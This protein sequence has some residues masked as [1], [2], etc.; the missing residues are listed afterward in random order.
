MNLLILGEP[1]NEDTNYR[2]V[3]RYPPFHIDALDDNHP[4]NRTFLLYL[5]LTN[6]DY[7]IHDL[8][9][10]REIVES[11]KT[12]TPPEIYEIIEVTDNKEPPEN[13]E[14]L[15]LGYDPAGK[16]GLSLISVLAPRPQIRHYVEYDKYSED[17]YWEEE[18]GI[19]H[20]IMLFNRLIREHFRPKLN[21]N[22]LFDDYDTAS[23][24]CECVMSILAV[25]PQCY[26]PGRY[27]VV[28]VYLVA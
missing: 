13:S 9:K 27:E 3:D 26:E 5:D 10:A 24:C 17:K 8:A 23:F 19:P 28:G 21:K 25:E 15:F 2:G 1:A 11:Y 20:H 18:R 22:L 12:L 7:L 14:A 16:I 6:E 4:V